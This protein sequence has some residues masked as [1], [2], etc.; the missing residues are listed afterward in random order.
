MWDP[1]SDLSVD[2][3]MV[4]RVTPDRS[5]PAS[6]LGMR[7]ASGCPA[8]QEERVVVKGKSELVG[9]SLSGI[10]LAISTDLPAEG[11]FPTIDPSICGGPAVRCCGLIRGITL[12]TRR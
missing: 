10:E 11:P 4:S 1:R 6:R 9:G 7:C 12:G 2:P 8:G 3:L 5:L